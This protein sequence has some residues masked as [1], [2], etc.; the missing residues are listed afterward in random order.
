ME[1]LSEE[2]SM[3][4]EPST[5]EASAMPDL[6]DTQDNL[7]TSILCCFRWCLHQM[8]SVVTI[9]KPNKVR[10]Q[11]V[12]P[13]VIALLSWQGVRSQAFGKFISVSL[14]HITSHEGVSSFMCMSLTVQHR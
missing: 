7:S 9:L 14:H 6:K 4:E 1:E 2:P 3:E 12:F 8:I 10:F 11:V 13:I 5:E